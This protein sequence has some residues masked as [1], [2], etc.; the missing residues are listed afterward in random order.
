MGERGGRERQNERKRETERKRDRE[1]GAC[2][3]VFGSAGAR[4]ARARTA[5]TG[6]TTSVA[7]GSASLAPPRST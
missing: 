5:L 4:P 6:P 7:T 1:K 2:D 3:A